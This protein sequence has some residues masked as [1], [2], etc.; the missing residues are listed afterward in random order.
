MERTSGGLTI[1]EA[2]AELTQPQVYHP[3]TVRRSVES[4][5]LLRNRIV[6]QGARI[7]RQDARQTWGAV[8]SVLA[9]AL[10]LR[11][12]E[13]PPATLSWRARFRGV[14][15]EMKAFVASTGMRLVL[16]RPNGPHF[17][18]EAP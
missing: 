13:P 3:E 11:N 10:T 17:T 5:Y 1:V 7:R 15:P 9:Q 6:H 12:V 2:A 18:M 14:R 8:E 16:A 4:A